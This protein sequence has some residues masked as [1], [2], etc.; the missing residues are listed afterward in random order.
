MN[1]KIPRLFCI[2]CSAFIAVMLCGF[3]IQTDILTVAAVICGLIA[4]VFGVLS[5]LRREVFGIPPLD[6][7][8]ILSSVLLALIISLLHYSRI[9]E[10]ERYIGEECHVKAEVSKIENE[11]VY[12]SSYQIEIM[13]IDGK[14]VSLRA[15]LENEFPCGFEVSD[16]FEARMIF[17]HTD[18]DIFGFDKNH[19]LL[20]KGIVMSAEG[21]YGTFNYLETGGF[22][23]LKWFDEINRSVSQRLKTLLGE[24][25]GSLASAMFLGNRD[26]IDA[27]VK[28]DFRRL[29][30]SHILALSGLHVSIII[31]GTERLLKL[32]RV[33]KGCRYG[34]LT[35]LALLFLG[36]VGFPLSAVRSVLML[37]IMYGAYYFSREN[38]QLTSLCFSVALI[39]GFS[40]ESAIDIGLILS[41]TATL[42]IILFSKHT[43]ALS[44][45]LLGGKGRL[46]FALRSVLESFLLSL[47]VMLFTLPF[48]WMSFGEISVIT[49]LSNIVFVPLSSV[50]LWLLPVVLLFGEV[51]FIGG[52]V[53][54]LCRSTTE[55]TVYL[56]KKAAEIPNITVSLRYDFTYYAVFGGIIAFVICLFALKKRHI[57]TMLVPILT[58]A[59]VFAPFYI[60]YN[61]SENDTVRIVYMTQKKNDGFA[62]KSDG[63]TLFCDISD[64][65]YTMSGFGKYIAENKFYSDDIDVYMLTHYHNRHIATFSK[66]SSSSYVRMLWLPE[67][68]SESE[69]KI[70]ADLSAI[71][72]DCSCGVSFY[73]ASAASG[74]NF[75]D[76]EIKLH[77]KAYL[78]RS[79]HPIFA[80]EINCEGQDLTYITSSYAEYSASSDV[81]NDRILSETNITVF[82]VHGPVIK[83]PLSGAILEFRPSLAVAASIDVCEKYGRGAD[84]VLDGSGDK[85]FLEIIIKDG[86]I[87]SAVQN[88]N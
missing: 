32:L 29:G 6:C 20:S 74:I 18:D 79:T 7:M 30:I 40:P 2:M 87:T 19:Y 12:S 25:A 64:G 55:L 36:V 21:V 35:V 34:L 67:P 75:G 88:N 3:Y 82:G 15:M 22:S 41:F 11:T 62:L 8:L 81:I 42:A 28:R 9:G 72:E 31:G 38:D 14:K 10:L 80:F 61:V 60:A 23:F 56:A 66:I 44:K 24:D 46:I 57:L 86:R 84:I 85:D 4:L 69:M 68:H 51:P 1:M 39:M 17:R 65:S 13:E 59:G 58:F 78:S 26:D 45:R 49:P 33:R 76:T 47:A 54:W 71:A 52:A 50:I 16:V 73:S 48:M 37:L 53:V 70:A 27:S 63:K 83:K 43:S 5:I 77:P